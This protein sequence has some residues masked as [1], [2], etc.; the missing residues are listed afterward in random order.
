M[1]HN[2]YEVILEDSEESQ[3]WLS[4]IER[5]KSSDS[6]YQFKL[7]AVNNM[8][9]RIRIEFKHSIYNKKTTTGLY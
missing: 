9:V 4:K 3:Q 8:K 1:Q 5:I 7:L 2:I 6:I